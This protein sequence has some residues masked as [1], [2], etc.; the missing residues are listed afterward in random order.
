MN[1]QRVFLKIIL[2]IQIN[3]DYIAGL[4]W[5]IIASLFQV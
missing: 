4:I 1:P 5:H 3:R 2:H